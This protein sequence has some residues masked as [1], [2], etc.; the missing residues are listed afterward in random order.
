MA[1]SIHTTLLSN[2]GLSLFVDIF[3]AQIDSFVYHGLDIRRLIPCVA[4][5]LIPSPRVFQHE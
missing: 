1:M 4:P 2:V 5:S 3:L